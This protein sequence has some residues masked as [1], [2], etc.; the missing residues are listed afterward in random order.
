MKPP[1]S[2]FAAG[3]C[4]PNPLA[5]AC[6]IP[7]GGAPQ[8]GGVNVQIQGSLA[9]PSTKEY[10]LGLA[11]TF[12]SS[13]RGSFRADVVRREFT[14]YYDLKKD[15]IT[16]KVT[17]PVGGSVQDL[18]LIV[19]SNDYRR[20]YTGLHTQFAYRLGASLNVGGVWTWSHLIG[21]IVGIDL[22]QEIDR[23]CDQPLVGPL[24]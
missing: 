18:G 21:D 8:I 22:R 24:G 15:T 16:G 7:Q 17:S 9:S 19:N 14:D 5:A 11:G 20:E 2:W 13:S 6:K 12:G 3:G 10:V 4:L 1:S 23:I